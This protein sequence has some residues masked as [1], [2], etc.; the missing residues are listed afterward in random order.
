MKKYIS[1]LIILLQSARIFSF[2]LWNGLDTTNNKNDIILQA[3]GLLQT[4]PLR[5]FSADS[6]KFD[7]YWPDYPFDHKFLPG[8][9]RSVIYHSPLPA[10]DQDYSG[11]YSS[12]N[13]RLYFINEILIC[14]EVCFSAEQNVISASL[15]SRY[16]RY[17]YIHN[18]PRF[19]SPFFLYI[20]DN[21]YIL[22][23]GQQVAYFDKSNYDNAVQNDINE[24]LI[25]DGIHF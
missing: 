3:S 9:L 17:R 8:K 24:R 11:Y 18:S 10:Y 25:Q 2:D 22:N 19:S 21:K 20:T 23:N 14:I 1:L 6:I 7:I 12:G 13:V 5:E 15:E 4:R 16:G